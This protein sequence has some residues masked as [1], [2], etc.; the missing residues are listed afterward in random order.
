MPNRKPPPKYQ[1]R[2]IRPVFSGLQNIHPTNKGASPARYERVSALMPNNR[3]PAAINQRGEAADIR[4]T[5]TYEP[6]RSTAAREKVFASGYHAK[7]KV[8]EA[9]RIAAASPATHFRVS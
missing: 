3:P 8:A 2:A 4:L 1:S 5:M 6:N 9:N 7:T